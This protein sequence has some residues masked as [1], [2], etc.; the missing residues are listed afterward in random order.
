MFWDLE[1]PL[2]LTGLTLVVGVPL[3]VVLLKLARVPLWIAILTVGVVAMVLFFPLV[4]MYRSLIDPTRFGEFHFDRGAEVMLPQVDTVPKAATEIVVHA[5]NDRHY[6]RFR[7]STEDR[8]AW[9]IEENIPRGTDPG[10]Y[11]DYAWEIYRGGDD[12]KHI[13]QHLGWEPSGPLVRVDFKSMSSNGAR[14]PIYW[15]PESDEVFTC[16]FYW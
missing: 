11:K 12:F 9:F 3:A 16:S 14:T 1:I 5:D 15:S 6:A 8:V 2:N 13:F 7:M 10:K 4:G